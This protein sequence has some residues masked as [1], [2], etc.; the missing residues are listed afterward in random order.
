MS[1]G[2]GEKPRIRE[3]MD[4]MGKR[5]RDAGFSN[6]YV[7]KKVRQLA[8]KEHTRQERGNRGK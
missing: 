5:L 2:Y 7:E 1:Y 6:D 4:K 8:E 3:A